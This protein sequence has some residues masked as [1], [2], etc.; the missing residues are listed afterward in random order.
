MAYMSQENKK[1]LSPAIKAVLK[2]YKMKGTIAVSNYST[3]VVNIK[4]GELDLIRVEN[5]QRKYLADRDLREFYPCKDHYINVNTHWADKQARDVGEE[6]V[7][8]FYEEL[9]AAMNGYDGKTAGVENFDKSDIM[10]DYFHVG[11]YIDVNVGKWDKPYE[12]TGKPAYDE[13]AEPSDEG[14]DGVLVA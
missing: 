2:K 10:T 13:V 8:N 5:K 6:T 11:W 12:Y 14:K 3:L 1:A 4:S 9:F 7:A